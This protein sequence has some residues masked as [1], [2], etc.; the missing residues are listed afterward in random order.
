MKKQALQNEEE[1]FYISF[2]A[3]TRRGEVLALRWKDVDFDLRIINTVQNKIGKVD[4][5]KKRN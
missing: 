5:T 1:A 4:G 3:G 2:Y